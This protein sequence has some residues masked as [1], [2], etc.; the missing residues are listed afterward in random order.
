VPNRGNLSP[1]DFERLLAWLAPDRDAAASKYLEIH[2][3]LSQI[4]RF[5]GCDCPEDLADVVIDRVANRLA[6]GR[7]TS[8]GCGDAY[9]PVFLSFTKY[10]F[11][12]YIRE[13]R[14]QDVP[15]TDE[16]VEPVNDVI[17][18]ER[19]HHCLETCLQ[20]LSSD[21]RELLPQY[22]RYSAGQKITHR[23]KLAQDRQTT[24]NA[25]RLK[26]SRLKSVVEG[27][28]RDCVQGPSNALRL[29]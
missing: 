6:K 12:E 22:H 28:V 29:Q 2:N 4:F 3:R 21:D 14:F 24:L 15:S 7:L 17:D 11:L 23:Q 1:D 19:R 26:V 8:T 10:V 9:L 25:L 5:R 18:I 16:L 20:Q 27:C 13:K